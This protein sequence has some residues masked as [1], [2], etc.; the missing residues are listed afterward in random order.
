MGDHDHGAGILAQVLFEPGDAFRVKVVGRLVKQDQVGL[1]KQQRAQRHAALLTARQRI[2][3]G[4]RRRAAQGFHRHL[5]LAVEVPEVLAVDD[6]L[7]FRALVGG[8]VGIV[9][10]QFVVAVEDRLLFGHALHHVSEHVQALVELRLLRQVAERRA[11]GQP[12]LAGELAVEP[13]HDPQDRRLTRA[14][15]TENTDLGVRVERQMNVFED[16][17]GAIGL[18]ESRHVIDELPCHVALQT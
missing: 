7:E 8:L 13:G 5:D 16:L 4:F 12:G 6:V 10:H 11:F 17:L 1:A 15:G 14:V 3:R 18:V 2:D 9:H